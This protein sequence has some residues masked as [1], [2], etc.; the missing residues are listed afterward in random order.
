MPI[1]LCLIVAANDI[2][3]C[4]S[5]AR[6]LAPAY[7]QRH[8][9]RV[10]NAA[11][12]SAHAASRRLTQAYR[13]NRQVLMISCQLSP[14]GTSP[15]VCATYERECSDHRCAALH[16]A[17]L[18]RTPSAVSTGS[19]LHAKMMRQRTYDRA[20]PSDH[21]SVAGLQQVADS[22]CCNCRGGRR[23]SS[24]LVQTLQKQVDCRCTCLATMQ[25]LGAT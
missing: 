4:L 25:E 13:V 11:R 7:T 22:A 1:T 19:M 8:C 3:V 10:P 5:K 24:R 15:S 16:F 14:A 20:S 9:L 21:W 23:A 17:L 18:L 12:N 2:S 6:C